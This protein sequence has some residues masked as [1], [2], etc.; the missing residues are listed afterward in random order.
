MNTNNISALCTGFCLL[1]TAAA[2]QATPEIYGQV[3][4]RIIDQEHHDR[5]IE[6]YDVRLGVKGQGKYANIT[7]LYELEAEYTAAVNDSDDNKNDDSE[8]EVRSARLLFPTQYGVFALAPKTPSS[9]Y[10]TLYGAVDIFETN[11]AYSDN[12]VS[13][14]FD[15]DQTSSHVIAWRSP[16]KY[17]FQGLISYLTGSTDSGTNSDYMTWWIEWKAGQDNALSGLRAAIGQVN[18]DSRAVHAHAD[19]DAMRTAA[20][21]SYTHNGLHL[22]ATYE[23]SDFQEFAN[24]D[25]ENYGLVASYTHKGYT[26]GAGYY[27]RRFDDDSMSFQDNSGTVITLQKRFD[28][29]LMFFIENGNFDLDEQSSLSIGAKLT[30]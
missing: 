5:S 2:A 9:Q 19:D 29:N 21:I 6:A 24:L 23:H 15:Q 17:G 25:R 3:A 12:G 26:L 8:L 20:T 4:A 18:I 22:G 27:E 30:F 28:E 14:I 1:S 11:R 13:H 7:V 10:Q 16:R